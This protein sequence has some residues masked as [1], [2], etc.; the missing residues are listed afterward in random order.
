MTIAKSNAHV[1]GTR[2]TTLVLPMGTQKYVVQRFL[3]LPTDLYYIEP[4]EGYV[5]MKAIFRKIWH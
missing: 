3:S 1:V 5:V 4:T 2:S